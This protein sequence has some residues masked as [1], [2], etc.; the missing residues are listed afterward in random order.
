MYV[1]GYAECKLIIYMYLTI[2]KLAQ[3]YKYNKS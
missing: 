2:R 3:I 1:F